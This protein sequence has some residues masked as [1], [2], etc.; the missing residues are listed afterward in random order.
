[1]TVV[2]FV[3][4]SVFNA[5]PAGLEGRHGSYCADRDDTTAEVPDHHATV[6]GLL[7][8]RPPHARAAQPTL[9]G[10]MIWTTA[11]YG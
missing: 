11:S 1:M 3:S 6:S 7:I 4:A 5:R 2:F 8:M 10:A 9:M